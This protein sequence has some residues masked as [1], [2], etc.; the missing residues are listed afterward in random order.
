MA[1]TSLALDTLELCCLYSSR[2]GWRRGSMSLVFY[3]E[4]C[5]KCGRK[6][7]SGSRPY[8]RTW[9]HKR[10]VLLQDARRAVGGSAVGPLLGGGLD[11]IG[12]AAG[13]PAVDAVRHMVRAKRTHHALSP[14]N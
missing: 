3:E 11:S 2:V 8:R 12:V 4:T 9:V 5:S 7:V 14:L 1:V 6:Q 10:V 13:G